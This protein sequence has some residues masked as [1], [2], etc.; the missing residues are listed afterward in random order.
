MAVSSGLYFL[1][2]EK[3]AID[4]ISE[5]IEAEDGTAGLV[6]DTYAPNFDTH[7]FHDDIT[8]EISGG[9]YA[10]DTVTATE[11][12]T[13]TGT[14]TFDHIDTLYDNGG[15]DDVTITNAEAQYFVLL[16]GSSA[17]DPLIYLL[18]FGSPASSTNSTFTTQINALGAFTID[19]TP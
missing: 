7:E 13:S 19:R 15:S 3:F 17:T 4:T 1:I 8:N 16:V 12:T 18:D 5:S 2:F 10:A 9:N 6:T 14:T 11:Y